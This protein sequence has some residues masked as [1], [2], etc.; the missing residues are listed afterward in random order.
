[1]TLQEKI[2]SFHIQIGHRGKVKLRSIVWLGKWDHRS[3]ETFETMIGGMIDGFRITTTAA[4]KEFVR[5]S[6]LRQVP[7]T[8]PQIQRSDMATTS[9]QVEPIC[10]PA[11]KSLISK[12]YENQQVPAKKSP[13]LNI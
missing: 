9:F 10:C 12:Q 8:L 13:F 11:F 1:M 3:R 5:E 7:T 6:Q 4:N 2:S